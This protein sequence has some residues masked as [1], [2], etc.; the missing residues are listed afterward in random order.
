M[1]SG[2]GLQDFVVRNT[3]LPALYDDTQSYTTGD[4]TTNGGDSPMQPAA[5]FSDY[6]QYTGS[7]VSYAGW[8]DNT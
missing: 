1:T 6:K 5:S 4:W 7:G 2:D 3:G 8:K